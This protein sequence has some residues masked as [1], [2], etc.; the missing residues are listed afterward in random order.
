MPEIKRDPKAKIFK[1][2]L[3]VE[4]RAEIEMPGVREAHVLCVQVQNGAPF[5]WAECR[6]DKEAMAKCSFYVVGTGHPMPRDAGVYL[7]TF[8]LE[9]LGLVFHVFH[10]DAG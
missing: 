7:G 1:Y 9:E 5:I 8:Q 3:P 4:D 10:D 2:P 6:L